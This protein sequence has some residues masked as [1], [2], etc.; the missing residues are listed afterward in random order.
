MASWEI[1][2][3]ALRGKSTI[4]DGFS[5]AT[6]DYRCGIVSAKKNAQT[7]PHP[8][9]PPKNSSLKE[10]IQTKSLLGGAVQVLGVTL[11]IKS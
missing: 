9:F 7:H 3:E 4:N 8:S 6:C 2:Y 1:H 5:I 10:K 11:V